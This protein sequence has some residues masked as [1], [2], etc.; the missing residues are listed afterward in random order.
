MRLPGN[1]ALEETPVGLF[2]SLESGKD[3]GTPRPLAD[4]MRP[5][6]LEEFVGQQH[7]L[8]P[9]KP[10]RTQIERDEISSLI[11]WGPPG[12]GKTTLASIIAQRCKG[13]FVRFSAVLSGIKEVK[14]V[15]EEAAMAR[16]T[17]VRTI[18]F[19]DE[20]HRFNKAQQDAFLPHVE[21]GDII[22]IGATTENPSFEVISAL[23][24]RSRVY[25]L[26]PL[27]TEDILILLRR[28]LADKERGLGNLDVEIA[29]P[30][31][32]QIAVFA[33]GDARIAFNVLESVVQGTQPSEGKVRI[34][35]E[36]LAATLERK[37]LLYDKAG[38]EHFNLIS[39]LHKSLR[40]SDPDAGVYWLARML[41]AG[42][43]PLYV[44]RRLVRFASEDVGL[45]D[46]QALA[47]SVAA[48]Q[49]VHFI[50]MPEGALALAEAAIYLALAP[51]SNS[52]YTAYDAAKE[53]VEKTV[54]QPVPLHLRNAPTPLMKAEGYG[55]GY[56]YAHD[57]EEKV[58]AMAC[59]PPNLEGKRYY[60]PMGQGL[61]EQFRRRLEEIRE[62]QRRASDK[63]HGH[64]RK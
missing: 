25:H 36:R 20:I 11:L 24:S 18:L 55:S 56:E 41:E 12:V 50:G 28:A 32:S 16:R 38:E 35:P 51:K 27:E 31:L 19:V 10:L 22:L 62:R 44:A 63:G 49:A 13:F 60:Q 21:K 61:E 7:L 8:A 42:E 29:E 6:T 53:D 52:L 17:G 46:P 47:L 5:A 9:G 14:A 54:A 40:N 1:G 48:M 33:N 57:L 26:A 58:S 34:A 15:M 23:L 59:L 45:A 2:G 37:T 64:P 39:A 30:L 3:A 43:D 4:R